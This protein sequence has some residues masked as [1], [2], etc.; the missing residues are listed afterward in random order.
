MKINEY[1][2]L[3]YFLVKV[4]IEPKHFESVL[5]RCLEINV[6]NGDTLKITF[7]VLISNPVFNFI[8]IENDILFN[9]SCQCIPKLLSLIF[10]H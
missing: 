4:N 6:L 2:N 9:D 10:T 3:N 1:T 5:L 7:A 8:N